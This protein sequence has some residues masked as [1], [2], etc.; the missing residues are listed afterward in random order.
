MIPLRTTLALLLLAA[1]LLAAGCTAGQVGSVWNNIGNSRIMIT[2]VPPSS[3]IPTI[4]ACPSQENSS[5]WIQINPV[6]DHYVGDIFEVNGTTT[7]NV[8]EKIL[9][10]IYQ[11]SILLPRGQDHYTSL[12]GFIIIKNGT[13]GLNTW[14]FSSNLSGFLPNEY[15]IEVKSV[16]QTVTNQTYFIV[17]AIQTISQNPSTMNS[18]KIQ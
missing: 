15:L 10:Q 4:T 3:P 6:S 9:I 5:L 7:C 17:N 2:T 18:N 13:C 11:S 16:N 14:A 8:K 1:V 12:N